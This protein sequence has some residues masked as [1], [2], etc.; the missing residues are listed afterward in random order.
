M[1]LIITIDIGTTAVR[2]IAFDLEGNS[3]G[4]KKGAYPTF[5][6]QPDSSEQD[7]E[8]VF[9][10]VLFMLKGLLNELFSDPK[11]R[12]VAI[13]F[14]SSMHSVLPIDKTGTPLGNAI[15]WADNRSKKVADEIKNSDMG[16]KIYEAT[17]TP[18]HAM[19]PLSK[20]TWIHKQQPERFA[21]VYK[22]ISIKEYVIYQFTN[23]YV[24]DFSLASA[25]G[26]FNIKQCKW[27]QQALDIAGITSNYLSDPSTIYHDGCK[28][29]PEL[30]KSLRLSRNTKIIIG[31]TDGCMATIGSGIFGD[32]QATL[33]LTSSGA[34][35]VLGVEQIHDKKQRL[36]N[37]ILDE[38]HIISGGP[39][40]NGGVVL[41]WYARQFGS[42]K[43]GIDF[44]ETMFDIFN[45]ALHV[46]PGANGL[47]FLPYLL[48][49]RAP[50]WDSNARGSYFGI[51]IRHEP[52][53]FA[54]ATI[55]GI[56]FELMS[57]SK[58]LEN[59][60][61]IKELSLT[62]TIETLPLWSE[63]IT[64]IFGLKVRVHHGVKNINLGSALVGLT[65][66]G[67]FE[68]IESAVKSI[69]P[70][71]V[72]VPNTSNHRLYQKYFKLFI[73]LTQ[74][75]KSEFKLLSELEN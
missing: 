38:N 1:E 5:H 36:F 9:I 19:S 48:G 75:L 27:E 46:S 32:G 26:M 25:T 35:R 58:V 49:E 22:F 18:I 41:D 17:G 65:Q 57:I 47:I 28:I 20:I 61:S 3:K 42:F 39:T 40:N 67:V 60:R 8:Q 33:S 4:Y 23:E 72:L 73:R 45:E 55:E 63:M 54:R 69:K 59:Y 68:N 21:K 24:I 13:V 2:I 34:V 15:I 53:H 50:I 16:P 6:A 29:N 62:G 30:A 70:S 64:D 7:P 66:L 74:K 43:S 11:N 12:V 14:S 10:T 31:S 56:I 52:K 44:D 51:N 37:Y 71:E